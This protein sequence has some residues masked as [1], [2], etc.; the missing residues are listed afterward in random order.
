VVRINGRPEAVTPDQ[1]AGAKRLM[2]STE[3]VPALSVKQVAAW[4]TIGRTS[5]HKPLED[6]R[7]PGSKAASDWALCADSEIHH[8]SRVLERDD[9][10]RAG[11]E[12]LDHTKKQ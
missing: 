9:R 6:A 1:V 8:M 10:R 3:G 4:V 11:A 5:F 12:G 2:A 7:E